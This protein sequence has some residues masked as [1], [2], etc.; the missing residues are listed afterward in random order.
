MA[1]QD[2]SVNHPF[3]AE[4]AL[5]FIFRDVPKEI[6]IPAVHQQV[7]SVVKIP[8]HETELPSA[9]SPGDA[10]VHP[11]FSAGFIFRS[12]DRIEH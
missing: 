8:I 3:I 2:T 9:T 6:D 11:K 5:S 10:V 7:Q 12:L 4:N 1:G